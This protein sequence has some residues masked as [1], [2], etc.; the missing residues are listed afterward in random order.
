MSRLVFPWWVQCLPHQQLLA[1]SSKSSIWL[2]YVFVPFCATFGLPL[3]ST[4]STSP[5]VTR[6]FF[7]IFNLT[8]IPR[9]R[10]VLCHVWSSLGECSVHL[11]SSYSL[12]LRNLQS[13][14]DITS[15]FRFVSRLVFPR[16][17]QC[18]PHQQLLAFS[19]WCLQ[20]RVWGTPAKWIIIII[21]YFCEGHPICF[22]MWR[23]GRIY[24]FLA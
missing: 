24:G 1:F 21:E 9:L 6:F 5:A 4:V 12:F 10:S 13:D 18:P 23:S 7:E 19:H 20:M 16:W 15:S 8:A 3:V 14:C 17:V 22:W 2:Q 11:T